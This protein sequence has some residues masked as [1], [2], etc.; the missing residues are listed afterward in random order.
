MN[1]LKIKGRKELE[2]PHI[3]EEKTRQKEQKHLRKN[4]GL[5]IYGTERKRRKTKTMFNSFDTY[6]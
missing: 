1:Q 5:N 3:E 2:L 4:N 6:S